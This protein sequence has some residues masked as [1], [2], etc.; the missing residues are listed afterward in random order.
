MIYNKYSFVILFL[1][2][3]Y[4]LLNIRPFTSFIKIAS[5]HLESPGTK[6]Y[7]AKEIK[8]ILKDCKSI[9]VNIELSHG[10]LLSS[11]VGQKHK[12]ILLSFSKF[13]WPRFIIKKFL[14]KY[15]LFILI[16]VVK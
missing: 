16:N 2:L 7:T 5:E 1:W 4:A 3:I 10:D 8:N 14:K 9:N 6:V 15:G 12:G 11:H 13:L